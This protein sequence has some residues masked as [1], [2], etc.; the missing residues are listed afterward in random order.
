VTDC[1]FCMIAN[2]TIP[3]TVV[4]QD[5]RVVAFADV[6][7]QAPVHVLVVPREHYDGLGSD[8]PAD[9]LAALF[10]AVPRVAEAAGVAGSGYRVIVN[11]GADAAQS[12]AHLHVH[13]LGGA[14]MSEGMLRL[15]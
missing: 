7:P 8:V 11:T 15:A 1:I 10:G 2:G 14:T 13:L 9:L 4:W 6:S 3:A 5:E 12:V